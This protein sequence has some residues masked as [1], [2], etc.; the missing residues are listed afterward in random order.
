MLSNS[1][2]GGENSL[3]IDRNS[4]LFYIREKPENECN[5]KRENGTEKD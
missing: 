3:G 5:E 4:A 1:K 2:E